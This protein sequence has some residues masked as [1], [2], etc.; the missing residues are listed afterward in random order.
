MI[1]HLRAIALL[2]SAVLLLGA[3][4]CAERDEGESI[5]E[6]MKPVMQDG[7]YY[8]LYVP[9][10]WASLTPQGMSG[11]YASIEHQVSVV[12]H[13]YDNPDGLSPE[14]YCQT[15]HVPAI[16]AA[17]GADYTLEI[18]QAPGIL[19]GVAAVTLTYDAISGEQNYCGMDVLCLHRDGVVVLSF[20]SDAQV[21]ADY[22]QE[23]TDVLQHFKLSDTPYKGEQAVNTVD[24]NAAAPDSMQ[25]ASND[26]VAY[27]FYVPSDWVLDS[28][29]ET[30]SA[31]VSEQ[32]RSSV[33]VTVYMPQESQ[34][35]AAEYWAQCQDVLR[36]TFPGV[37]FLSQTEGT[38]GGRPANIY[39]YTAEMNGTVYCFAQ[40]IASYRGMIY[41]V[42]YTATQVQFDAHLDEYG[43]IVAAF[44]FR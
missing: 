14:E 37:E 35:S 10:E 34:L 1:K 5:P 39:Q 13:T 12:V 28:A 27:R 9:V 18:N 30:S 21:F 7:C 38:L 40:T 19:G 25:L 26:D 41:T 15:V 3:V 43:Q 20:L 2:L 8:R 42:T 4:G 31:Y 29:M 22:E 23:R 17:Y 32:D 44:T 24:R 11:A 16:R 33:N 36:H 6:N